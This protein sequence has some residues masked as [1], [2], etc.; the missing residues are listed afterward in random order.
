[1]TKIKINKRYI[2]FLLMKLKTLL[3]ETKVERDRLDNIIHS[4]NSM[5]SE[6]YEPCDIANGKIQAYEEIISLVSSP[7]KQDKNPSSSTN[8]LENLKGFY[9]EESLE[10]LYATIYR[11]LVTSP[12]T[13][14]ELID[15]INLYTSQKRKGINPERYL[16]LLD[17]PYLQQFILEMEK[18]YGGK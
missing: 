16:N 6:Y 5:A 12:T 4:G 15:I 7:I 3:E 13:L 18:V 10:E 1:M 9:L 17:M 11:C 2:C 14:R 8:S